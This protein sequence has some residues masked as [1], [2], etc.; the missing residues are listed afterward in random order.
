MVFEPISVNGHTWPT[1]GSWWCEAHGQVCDPW[2]PVTAADLLKRAAKSESLD[3]GAFVALS[4]VLRGDDP[5][6]QGGDL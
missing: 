3:D 5:A 2:K 6:D 1:W 4:R